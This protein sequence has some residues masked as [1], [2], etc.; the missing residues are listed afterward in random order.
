M[1]RAWMQTLTGRAL[2]MAQPAPREIDP[3]LDIPEMLARIARFNGAV[4]GGVYSVAQHSVHIADAILDDTGD[5]DTAAI[6]LVHDAHE[7]IWGDVT[8]PAQDG[9]SEI[10]AELYGDSRFEAVLR[11][12]KRRADQAIFRACGIPWPPTQQQL[13]TVKAYDLRMLA[14]ERRQ[15]LSPCGKRWPAAIEKA[16]P[17]RM[18]GGISIWPVARAAEEF[19]DRLRRLCPAVARSSSHP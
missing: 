2:T 7:Y 3:L 8:T 11:E 19:S 1:T 14:T 5:A 13:R 12:A 4:P 16:P 9:L 17:L 10:E 15:L 18:R 6:G